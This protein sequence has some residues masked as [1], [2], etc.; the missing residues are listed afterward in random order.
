MTARAVAA[1][2]TLLNQSVDLIRPGGE[3]WFFKSAAQT[4]AERAAAEKAGAGHGLRPVEPYRY[5]LPGD[6]ADRVVL[7]Y[8]K[9]S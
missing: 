6:A 2:A 9:A 5:K 3:G 1:L 7:V 4:D 8:R